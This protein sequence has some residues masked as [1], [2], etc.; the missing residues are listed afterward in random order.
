MQYQLN[1]S[2]MVFLHFV[3]VLTRV[4]VEFVRCIVSSAQVAHPHADSIHG[5]RRVM[6]AGI[7]PT[8]WHLRAFIHHFVLG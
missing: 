6:L 3:A 1:R 8:F 4:G 2:V 5:I 7:A